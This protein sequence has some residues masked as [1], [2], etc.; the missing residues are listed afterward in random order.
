MEACPNH[1]TGKRVKR[2]IGL[3]LRIGFSW[4]LSTCMDHIHGPL[5]PRHLNSGRI[6]KQC[7]ERYHNH[8][9]PGLRKDDFTRE[10]EEVIAELQARL[11]NRWSE[12]AKAL[13]GRTDNAIKNHWN[14]GKMGE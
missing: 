4:N 13:P 11:G 3:Q 5:L 2:N 14:S 9:C 7:R 1:S 12:I 8:L 6:G 10:E